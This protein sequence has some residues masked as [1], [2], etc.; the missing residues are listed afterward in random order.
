MSKLKTKKR[1]V[2]QWQLQACDHTTNNNFKVNFY[3]PEFSATKIVTWACH[4]DYSSEIRHN[5]I[6]SRH[7]L[8][9][10]VLNL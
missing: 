7:L 10:L 9:P 5:M 8:T 1:A 2:T 3:L 4:V 6:L